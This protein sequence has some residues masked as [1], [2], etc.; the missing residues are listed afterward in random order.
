MKEIAKM[1]IV[2]S[3]ICA[4]CGALLALVFNGTKETIEI[5][6]LKNVKEPAVKKVLEGAE[7]DLIADRKIVKISAKEEVIV[8]IGKKDGKNWA[9]AFEAMGKGGYGGDIG[10][11]VG[12]E[13]NNDIITGIG[14]TTHKETPGLGEKVK[15][16]ESFS[17]QF[18]KKALD[19]NF[20]VDKDGGDI[21]AISGA[22]LSSRAVSNAVRSA[23]K[24]KE[25]IQ[26]KL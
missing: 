2:L 17:K 10:V 4:F 26:S 25:N 1:L 8:F 9:F 12:F 3:L 5:Q 11:I 22:T 20:N 19:T 21:D 15:T 13:F 18:S 14:V 16:Q 24:L 6:L 7:N 23:L